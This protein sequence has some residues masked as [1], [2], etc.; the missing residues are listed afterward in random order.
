MCNPG[1]ITHLCF[2]RELE[3]AKNISLQESSTKEPETRPVLLKSVDTGGGGVGMRKIKQELNQPR[4]EQDKPKGC[5]PERKKPP[6]LEHFKSSPQAVSKVAKCNAATDEEDED[7]GKD[8]WPSLGLDALQKSPPAA[9][10]NVSF[11]PMFGVPNN[12]GPLGVLPPPPGFSSS[13]IVTVNPKNK[14]STESDIFEDAQKLLGYDT[15]K[16]NYFRAQSGRYQK[17]DISV[18][19]YHHNCSELFGENWTEFGSRL[20]DTLPNLKKRQELH[21]ILTSNRQSVNRPKPPPGFTAPSFSKDATTASTVCRNSNFQETK[22][23]KKKRNRQENNI[24][25]NSTTTSVS[26]GGNGGGAWN[27]VGSTSRIKLND[28]EF[29]SLGNAA[30][31][32]DP[33][34]TMPTWNMKVAV[35]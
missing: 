19:E 14:L 27:I 11:L 26:T 24:R 23:S 18:L 12:P 13:S 30:Q 33:S 2:V 31:M 3:T 34:V 35:N 7:K 8:E 9:T 5:P 22:K 17:G 10:V 16:I 25:S 20:A 1:T 6:G 29:P 28:S 4:V 32:P 21:L 15:G